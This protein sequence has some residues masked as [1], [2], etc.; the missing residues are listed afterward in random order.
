MAGWVLPDFSSHFPLHAHNSSLCVQ[1]S[2]RTCQGASH[3]GGAPQGPCHTWGPDGPLPPASFLPSLERR[4]VGGVHPA[5]KCDRDPGEH[6]L[7]DL[8]PDKSY[9]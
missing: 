4:Q 2:H 5:P 7:S 8:P 3:S 1:I 6:L 9:D